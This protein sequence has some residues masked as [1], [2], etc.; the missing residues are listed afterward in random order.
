MWRWLKSSVRLSRIDRFR[1]RS[2]SRLFSMTMWAW[3]ATWARKRLASPASMR[4]DRLAADGEQAARAGRSSRWGRRR[5]RPS[6][7]S[8][9]P[10]PLP[11]GAKSRACTWPN[12]RAGPLAAAIASSRRALA[13]STTARGGRAVQRG[14]RRRGRPRSTKAMAPI[15]KSTTRATSAHDRGEASR[16]SCTR[17][18]ATRPISERIVAS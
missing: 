15:V 9:A 18:R 5:S 8:S 14:A 12:G 11:A 4:A 6:D 13:S 10:C 7:V 1:T 2:K 3:F 17:L 16:R